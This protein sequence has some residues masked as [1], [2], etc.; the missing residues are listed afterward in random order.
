MREV[1]ERMNMRDVTICYGLTETSPVFTQTRWTMTFP[2]SARPW[3]GP[4]RRWKCAC[5]M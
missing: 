3:A 4:I 1:M 5:S 2:T